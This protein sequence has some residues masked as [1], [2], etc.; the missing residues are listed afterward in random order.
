MYIPP[1]WYLHGSYQA[2]PSAVWQLGVLLYNM[3]SG[4][5]PFRKPDHVLYCDPIPSMD[6]FSSRKPR[7]HTQTREINTH[8][9]TEAHTCFLSV[10]N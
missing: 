7:I 8:T 9:H 3:L 1:E 4:I 6:G 2:V 5:F 10:S